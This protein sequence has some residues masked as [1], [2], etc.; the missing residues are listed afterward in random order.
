[1]SGYF[2]ENVR[3][4]AV[5]YK[6]GFGNKG[7]VEEEYSKSLGR[8]TLHRKVALTP[9]QWH[10]LNPVEIKTKRLR[11]RPNEAHHM[12]AIHAIGAQQQVAQNLGSFPHPLDMAF[13]EERLERGRWNGWFHIADPAGT[14]LGMIGFHSPTQGQEDDIGIG[15]ALDPKA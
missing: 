3:S 6:L 13:M 4:A 14:V 11:I 10:F 5:L 12:T 9:E 2:I 15:Y 8:K 7:P 1:M